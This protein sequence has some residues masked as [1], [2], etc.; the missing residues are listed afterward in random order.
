MRRSVSFLVVEHLAMMQI[1]LGDFPKEFVQKL[2]PQGSKYFR[3]DG[4]VDF[5]NAETPKSSVK[6]VKGLKPLH[7]SFGDGLFP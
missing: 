6:F 3:K 5:P 7:V 2:G 4:K 1:I